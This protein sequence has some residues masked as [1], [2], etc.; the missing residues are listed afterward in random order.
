MDLQGGRASTSPLFSPA[1]IA[2]S[3]FPGI[4]ALAT[5][6]VLAIERGLP[7]NDA[8]SLTF[9]SLVLIVLGWVDNRVSLDTV[10]TC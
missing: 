2:W 9:V 5:L 8:R 6:Y 4:L 1:L 7:E 3:L 10:A